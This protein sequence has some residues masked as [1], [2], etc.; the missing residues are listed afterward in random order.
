LK[1]LRDLNAREAA[2]S[3]QELGLAP[4]SLV[5]ANKQLIIIGGLF[6][7]LIGH[8]ETVSSNPFANTTIV[9]K[10]NLREEREP[11][12]LTDLIK[13]F[14]APVFTG[15]QSETHWNRPG[16]VVLRESAKFWVPILGLFTGARL[17][18]ICKLRVADI[19]HDE[20]VDYIDI[21]AEKHTDAA[22]DPTLKTSASCRQI[23]I[24][25]DLV[26]IGFLTFLQF[27]NARGDERLFLELK[28]DAYGKLADGFGKHFARF[29]KG[30]GIKR[31]KID[32]HSFRHTWTDACRNSRISSARFTNG[33]RD[34][35]R[36]QVARMLV[37]AGWQ[38]RQVL[39]QTSVG[40]LRRGSV[41]SNRLADRAT[42]APPLVR[43]MNSGRLT[44]L[45]RRR[46]P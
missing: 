29:L 8:Y 20:G 22:I 10:S 9:T 31:D 5:N 21:N 24:H 2:K 32:F 4:M 18:E 36:H 3:A 14:Q 28:P 1:E 45:P 43:P 25:P 30:L 40:R 17:N 34:E 41:S 33:Q 35:C 13:I 6:K 16:N 23:P 39:L 42:I 26:R 46:G 12:T 7:W 15:C 38:P 27:R 11:F 19:R 44:R 37:P